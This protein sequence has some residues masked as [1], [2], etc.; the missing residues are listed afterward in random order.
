MKALGLILIPALLSLSGIVSNGRSIETPRLLSGDSTS[1]VIFSEDFEDTLSDDLASNFTLDGGMG[2]VSKTNELFTIPFTGVESNNYEIDFDLKYVTDKTS[3]VYIHLVDLDAAGGNMYLS[4]EGSGAYLSM[5]STV[6]SGEVYNNGGDFYGGL[7]YNAVDLVNGSH[8]KIVTFENYIELWANGTRRFV[9]NLSAF[10]GTQYQSY[11]RSAITKGTMT[12]LGIHVVEES[13]VLMDNITIAEAVR[14]ESYYSE[15]NPNANKYSILGASAEYFAYDN[16]RVSAD[17][18]C[19]DI[20]KS[21]SYPVIKLEG[22]NGSLFG[23]NV[24]SSFNFQF[25]D[26]EASLTP[27]V[28]AQ[29]SDGSGEWTGVE[30]TAVTAAVGDTI[31]YVIEVIGD[32]IKTYLNGNLAIDTSFTALSVPK[33]ALQY[34]MVRPGESGYSWTRADYKGFD[35]TSGAIASIEK[36]EW[37][38]GSEVTATAELFGDRSQTYTWYLDDVATDQTGL[39]YTSSTLAVGDH[40][41]QYKNDTY[42]SNILN[43]KVSEGIITI[44]ADN[45]EIY[46][47]DQVTLTATF[48][49]AFADEAATEWYL[50]GT[51]DAQTGATAAFSGLAVGE[52]E[53]YAVNEAVTSNTVTITVLEPSITISAPKSAYSEEDDAVVTAVAHGF[54]DNPTFAWYI[55][56]KVV[57]GATT[58]TLTVDMSQYTRGQQ[59]IVQCAIGDV[60]SNDFVLTIYYDIP[61]VVTSDPYYQIISEMDIE[62]GGSY[63]TYLVGSDADGNYLY[64]DPTT[65]GPNCPIT[66][67]MPTSSSYTYEYK[68]YVP[69]ELPDEYYVYPCLIGADSKYPNQAMEVAFAINSTGMRPYI[70]D[71]GAN[72]NYDDASGAVIA[73]Y[74]YETGC[75]KKGDW[76][77]VMFAVQNKSVAVSLNGTPV[78]FFT[79]PSITVPTGLSM[80]WWSAA[81]NGT[82]IPLRVKDIKIGA[83]VEPAPDLESITLSASTVACK[84]NETVTITAVINPFNAEVESYD[85]YINDVLQDVHGNSLMFTP[86]EAGEYSIVCKVG[87]ISSAPKTI[88]VTAGDTASEPTSEDGGGTGGC[89]GGCGGTIGGAAGAGAVAIIAAIGLFAVRRKKHQ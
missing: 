64:A 48:D 49:G 53:I 76:N 47:T 65:V 89:G 38:S 67:T 57:D 42:E 7:D 63:G 88:T 26:S 13:S 72:V 52:H 55:D 22:L 58:D 23:H 60:L 44:A 79:L 80:N 81:G 25:H 8:F 51:K 59:I 19:N 21:D 20:T 66:G 11:S 74:T 41:L 54:G 83:I 9:A 36:E 82:N 31:H 39:T 87:D 46:P 56:S 71:Q 30:A 15:T 73:D 29:K 85:W 75:A 78:L 40:T 84:V 70:K 5:R 3:I 2:L 68:L 1:N 61:A 18:L 62:E 69:E 10:G 43:V 4:I 16:F 6:S 27:Q 86:T 12:A 17:F 37:T 50:D 28:Y 14:N 24:E 34:I 45:T 77:Q 32:S 35:E 33:G